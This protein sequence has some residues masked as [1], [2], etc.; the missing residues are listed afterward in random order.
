MKHALSLGVG[1]FC[2]WLLL[3][4]HFDPLL[5][6]LGL[7]ST[8]LTVYLALRM[9]VLDH[10]SHPLH[11][12]FALLRFWAYLVWQIVLANV[13][14]ASRVLG[15]RPISPTLVRLPLPLKTDLG[16][17][18]YAN[19]ITLTPGTVS[20]EVDSDTVLVHALSKEAAADLQAGRMAR[21]VPDIE[22]HEL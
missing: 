16:R 9:E 4:G 17:V 12:S 8:V 20:L 3:S 14:V 19:S 10:E 2:L 22:V 18:I 11:L 21:L 7:F 6:G 15:L 5:L 13:D 1:L